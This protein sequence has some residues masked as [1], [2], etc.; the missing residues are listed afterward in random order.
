MNFLRSTVQKI[1]LDFYL[2]VY[3]L[4]GEQFKQS[5]AFG[6]VVAKKEVEKGF[7]V[8]YQDILDLLRRQDTDD[9]DGELLDATFNRT[10][11]CS[12]EEFKNKKARFFEPK[13]VNAFIYL[14]ED[15]KF[16]YPCYFN[17]SD[18]DEIVKVSSGVGKKKKRVIVFENVTA[19]M[20]PERPDFYLSGTETETKNGIERVW[21]LWKN[22]ERVECDR[23]IFT[24]LFYHNCF[25][26]NWGICNDF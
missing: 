12:F 22:N 25:G 11:F 18:F 26:D 9:F 5:V 4:D 6:K 2:S 8:A 23:I 19:V 3:R 13:T 24:D 1:T 20:N 16:R 15:P 17:A 10:A 7:L 14:K 21:E